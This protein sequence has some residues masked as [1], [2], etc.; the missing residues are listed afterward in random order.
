MAHKPHTTSHPGAR[1]VAL[2]KL[3]PPGLH[4]ERS[5]ELRV[6]QQSNGPARMFGLWPQRVGQ[7]RMAR[8]G[9]LVAARQPNP[10][11]AQHLTALPQSLRLESRGP[12]C[13]QGSPKQSDLMI[14][15]TIATSVDSGA[16]P[17]S[18]DTHL[19]SNFF[20]AANVFLVF[21]R[22]R[23]SDQCKCKEKFRY[24]QFLT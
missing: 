8:R 22:A 24:I 13:P 4:T 7:I 16:T 9:L 2:L 18:D 12:I 17:D 11:R 19:N 21:A 3:R 10:S 20:L 1:P 15:T 5:G 23:E 6:I 14:T